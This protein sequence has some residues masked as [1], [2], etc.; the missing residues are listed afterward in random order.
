ML[1]QRTTDVCSR[2][3]IT[4]TVEFSIFCENKNSE[5]VQ[6]MQHIVGTNVCCVCVCVCVCVCIYGLASC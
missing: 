3:T 1:L 2:L 4:K 5:Q 6:T